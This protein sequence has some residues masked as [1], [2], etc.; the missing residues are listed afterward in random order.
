MGKEE[1]GEGGGALRATLLVFLNVRSVF[2]RERVFPPHCVRGRGTCRALAE[3]FKE[4]NPHPPSLSPQFA[5]RSTTL[6]VVPLLT[7]YGL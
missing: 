4:R 6:I 5:S 3:Y 7:A 1:E 2:R